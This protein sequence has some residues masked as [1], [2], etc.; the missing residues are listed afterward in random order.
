M[1]DGIDLPAQEFELGSA[2]TEP[3]RRDVSH[4]DPYARRERFV[5]DLGFG[6]CMAQAI[7][8]V[9]GTAGADDAVHQQAG[10]AAKQIA[11]HE[12]PHESRRPGEENLPEFRRRNRCRR[13]AVI[14]HRTNKSTQGLDVLPA[15]PWQ[16]GC[17]RR[18]PHVIDGCIHHLLL[19]PETH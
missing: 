1:V 6:Q 17:E 3:H 5:P 18:N 2:Q 7:E 19:L 4:H 11:Q 9:F 8:T 16:L 12:A 14:Q 15:M 10:V 13:H